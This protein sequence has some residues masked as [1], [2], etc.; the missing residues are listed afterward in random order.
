[1][2]ARS[3]TACRESASTYYSR[4]IGLR[5]GRQDVDRMAAHFTDNANLIV[6]NSPTMTGKDAIAKQ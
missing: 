4:D 1:M 5:L 2:R 3:R 6:P